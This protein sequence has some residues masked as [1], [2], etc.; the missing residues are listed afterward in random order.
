MTGSAAGL[1][2]LEYRQTMNMQGQHEFGPELAQRFRDDGYVC[3]PDFLDAVT[4]AAILDRITA[5]KSGNIKGIPPEKIY[6]EDKESPDTLKQIQ[7]LYRWDG[8]F[9]ELMF[10][11]SAI[12][13]AR[14]LL[15]DDVVGRNMQY[16]N[17]P[18]SVGQPTPPHQDGFYFML[19][20]CEAVTM[21]L[22]LEPVDEETGCVRY[23]RGSHK[24][25]LQDHARTETL[26]FSQAVTDYDG[27]R[28][29]YEEI[30][31]PAAPGT[32]LAHHALT[33]HRADRNRSQIRTRQALGFI[34]YAARAKEDTARH[35][36]YQRQLAAELEG[37]GKI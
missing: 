7:D 32:L 24:A 26:G 18:P 16:F 6:Y 11:G 9:H 15:K 29:Q 22:A 23:L 19:R 27:L 36:A 17:K 3:I 2:N 37:A 30:A 14:T 1:P 34:F 5:I 8:L 10:E 4:V 33:V 21:W 31:F 35:A 13:L 25:G 20:P 28:A 12:R